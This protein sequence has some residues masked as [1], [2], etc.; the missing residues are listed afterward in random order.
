[1]AATI[2][3]EGIYAV[4]NLRESSTHRASTEEGSFQNVNYLWVKIKNM[5]ALEFIT[6]IK[7]NRIQIP[8]RIQSELK[9]NQDQ[10][11]RVIVLIDDSEKNDN[12][13]LKQAA[14]AHFLQGYAETDSIYDNNDHGKV[15]IW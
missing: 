14:E 11:V 9:A 12:L 6:K 5:K 1:M 7:D 2:Y 15:S 13:I 4:V 8:L 10:N 3:T